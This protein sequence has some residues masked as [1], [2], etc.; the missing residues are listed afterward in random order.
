MKRYSPKE[1]EEKWQKYWQE[2]NTY[3]ANLESDKPK[4]IA[5]SM[6]NYPSGILHVGHSMNYS[7]SDVKARFKRQQGYESYHPIGWDAFGTPA[8]NL[9]VKTGKS[10]QEI[11]ADILPKYRQLYQKMGWSNDWEKEISTHT[12]E[13]YKWTQWL[14]AQLYKDSLA[15]Q[16]GRS[17]WWCEHCQSVLSDEQVLGG[18]CWRHDSGEDPLVGKKDVKQ[19]FFKITDYADELLEATDGL[20]W[21]ES[22]KI[23]QKNWIGRSEGIVTK[24]K[25]RDTELEIESFSAHFEAFTANTF[26]VIAPDHP[27]LPTLLDGVPSKDKI[28]KAAQKMASRRDQEGPKALGITEGVFTERFAVDAF[29]DAD[30]PIWIASYAIADYGTGI[31]LCSAHDDR[32]F[33]FAKKYGIRLKPTMVPSDPTEA[34]KVKNLE[35]CFTDMSNGVLIEPSSFA[36]KKTSESRQEIADHLEAEGIATKKTTYK[37]RDWSIS[38]QRY[39]GAP[40][41]IVYCEKCG[42]VL[43][44]ETEY[45][46][47][48]PELE[49]FAPSGDGRSALARAQDWIKTR[50]PDCGC[51]AERETETMDGYVCSSW[52]MYRYFSPHDQNRIFDKEIVDKWGPINF[53]NGGDHAVAHLLYARFIARFLHKIGLTKVVEPFDQM[54]FNGKV[55]ASDGSEF[56]KRKGNG[57]DPLEIINHGYGA[58]ALRTYLMF[59]APLDQNV[60]W[61]P[62]GVP[63]VYRFLNRVWNL[64]QEFLEVNQDA[65]PE[66]QKIELDP[67]IEK[68]ILSTSHKAVKKVTEDIENDKFNTAVAAMMEATN[69]FFKIKEHDGGKMIDDKNGTWRSSLMNLLAVL[70]PFA[71]HITE[72][73]WQDLGHSS[74]IHIDTWPKWDEKYLV[75]ETIKIAVQINGKLKSEIEV[76][77]NAEKVDVLKTAKGDSKVGNVIGD[78]EIK[79]E[80]Y[81][82]GKIV[83]FVI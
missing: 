68:Q 41:P 82:P 28:L 58:D 22:V 15:Y 42:P 62:N 54:F 12:P 51:S 57:P 36:G 26:V 9:A 79:K 3:T 24:N 45:P 6:F 23:A 34:E 31:V 25:V 72:E 56:S 46:I 67:E 77:A 16:D 32:D 83:N 5:M 78:K 33:E 8:E 1:I 40:I 65:Q 29:G 50:C 11:I 48:L 27:F 19:W 69:S 47:V 38:R 13:Y 4:Y 10:P 61:D 64:V 21:T 17:Q 37:M 7:I 71:P 75:S 30:L 73:L 74:T 53:Y 70:A 76:D 44:P 80:I 52:Y 81:V 49:D 63:G 66:G 55:R 59:A 2:S 39:W 43:V 18:K 14:F 35:Y 60:N 20:N